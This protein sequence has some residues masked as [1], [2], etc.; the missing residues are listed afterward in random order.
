MKKKKWIILQALAIVALASACNSEEPHLDNPPATVDDVVRI[1]ATMP[2]E[3]WDVTDGNVPST[4]AV[5]NPDGSGTFEH[6]DSLQL[7]TIREHNGGWS[8]RTRVYGVGKTKLKWSDL[9]PD[10]TALIIGAAYP[11][12]I[13]KNSEFDLASAPNPDLL[14]ASVK[15]EYGRPVRLAFRHAMHRLN[16]VIEG[17]TDEEKAVA[18]VSLRN[19]K[20]K[21]RINFENTNYPVTS[22]I[23]EAPGNYP[24]QTPVQG[25]CSFIVPPQKV[26][27]A[28]E[29][30]DIEVGGK[31]YIYKTEGVITTL[32][33]GKQSTLII[34][35]QKGEQPTPQ[36]GDDNEAKLKV[37]KE[38]IEAATGTTIKKIKLDS[39]I[40]LTE[41]ITIPEGKKVEIDGEG[42]YKLIPGVSATMT[43][44]KPA[45]VM[46]PNGELILK[47]LTVD[48]NN[49]EMLSP[50][51]EV[52][53]TDRKMARLTLGNGFR[54][55]GCHSKS[56]GHDAHTYGIRTAGMLFMEKGAEITGNGPGCAVQ[57]TG[58]LGMIQLK[59]GKIT[60]NEGHNLRLDYNDK[61]PNRQRILFS[62]LQK[63]PKECLFGLTLFHYVN[64]QMIK[65]SGLVAMGHQLF[66]NRDRLKLE[67]II[68]DQGEDIRIEGR[69]RIG[70]DDI[71]TKL[72]RW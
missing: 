12:N 13:L 62:E 5:I 8:T 56:Q 22:N 36:P 50:A 18:R 68:S 20:S 66:S 44:S 69:F 37:L 31:H 15:T 67:H 25:R 35:V 21:G 19:L 71:Q 4:R 54:M 42:K 57:I 14:I 2:Q 55:T 61:T 45:I 29:L 30:A 34:T 53:G 9:S 52:Q 59:G 47:Q 10:K 27:E 39:D 33:S 16:I 48:G 26:P 3:N 1:I 58:E 60:G 49:A 28:T 63:L 72:I 64:R 38:A 40:T 23:G 7:F 32:E 51:I 46:E 70:G 6:G 24:A 43:T 65:G 17:L 11:H 41:Q